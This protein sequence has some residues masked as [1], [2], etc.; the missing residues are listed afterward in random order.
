MFGQESC[1][2]DDS[3]REERSEAEAE[4]G[5]EDCGSEEGRD[6][7]EEE[8]ECYGEGEVD[9]W[10]GNVLACIAKVKSCCCNH[11]G[12]SGSR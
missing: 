6:E 2:G 3:A 11:F 9:L 8:V 1:G 5:D 4:E 12:L 10:E 7:P